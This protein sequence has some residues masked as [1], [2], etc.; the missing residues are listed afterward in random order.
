MDSI[1]ALIVHAV[2]LVQN[3]AKHVLIK[4]I[5]HLVLEVMLLLQMELVYLAYLIVD[6]VLLNHHPHVSNVGMAF[7]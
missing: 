6:N 4:H 5:V 7:I 1:W 3:Y 2:N